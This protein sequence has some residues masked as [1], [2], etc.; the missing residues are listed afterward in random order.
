MTTTGAIDW[1]NRLDDRNAPFFRAAGSMF[2]NFGWTRA[3][4][5]SSAALAERLGRSRYELWAGIDV[6]A[7]GRDTPVDWD[8]VV[9]SYG[10]Y[11]PE[12]TWRT[13]PRN[14]PAAFHARDDRFWLETDARW[15]AP[16]GLVAARSTVTALP[17]ASAFNTGHGTGWWERGRRTSGRPWSHLGL[18]D[19]LPARRRSVRFDFTDAWYGG[20]SLLVDDTFDAPTTVELFATRLR[21]SPTAVLELTHRGGPPGA[22]LAVTV[23]GRTTYLPV[24]G[25]GPGWTTTVLPLGH[26]RGTVDALGLRLRPGRVHWRL[27]RLAVYDGTAPPPPPRPGSPAVTASALNPD[28]SAALRVTWRTT[29]H[30]VRHYTLHQRLPGGG[31]RFLGGTCGHAYY[32]PALIRTAG[33]AVTRVEVRAVDELYVSSAPAPFLFPWPTQG[34]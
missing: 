19:R 31:A 21:L 15:R 4:L 25:Q 24:R 30:P 5:R 22:D 28:G 3:G 1:R 26:L 7:R 13:A 10:F 20:S 29:G 12:W 23:D 14:D 11:R 6:E 8:A 34:S 9:T 17:F 27:G 32:V 18:Q 16:A 33:E 2:L